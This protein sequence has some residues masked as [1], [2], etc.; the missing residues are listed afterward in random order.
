[1]LSDEN[2]LIGTGSACASRSTT[3]QNGSYVLK[4]YGFKDDDTYGLI[5]F[6]FTYNQHD[7]LPYMLDKF[8]Q[9]IQN[10]CHLV[11]TDK[12]LDASHSARH[13]MP[14]YVNKNTDIKQTQ[15]NIK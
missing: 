12:F 15:Q 8:E 1:M 5:R 9:T 6:T 11:E 3:S 13:S 14:F 10:L 7:Q 2:I 4:A